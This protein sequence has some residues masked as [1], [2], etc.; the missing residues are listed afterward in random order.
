MVHRTVSGKIKLF[1]KKQIS[2]ICQLIFLDKAIDVTN[3]LPAGPLLVIAPHPDDETL[4]C[5]G[6]MKRFREQGHVVRIIIVTDGG[7]ANLPGKPLRQEIAALRRRE[8]INAANILG[9]PAE[10]VLFLAYPD[11]EAQEHLPR[12]A[13]D[14]ASQIWLYQPALILAPHGIDAHADHRAVANVMQLLKN[15]GKVTC[16]VLEYP[17]WFWPRGALTHLRSSALMKTHRKISVKDFLAQKQQA[18]NAHECQKGEENWDQLEAY[19]IAAN[20]REDELFFDT[21]QK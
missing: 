8:S 10:E 15:D 20:L 12:I 1:L 14:I 16:P 6:V 11:G 18:I 21:D 2:A 4:G 3:T 7:S 17:M 5:A 13:D 9:I 19:S